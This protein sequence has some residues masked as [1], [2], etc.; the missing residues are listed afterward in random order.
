MVKVRISDLLAL[1]SNC[2][3]MA[4]AIDLLIGEEQKFLK[5]ESPEKTTAVYLEPTEWSPTDFR[6]P[7]AVQAILRYAVNQLGSQANLARRIIHL[8]IDPLGRSLS[9]LQV[10]ISAWLK[11]KTSPQQHNRQLLTELANK[12]NIPRTVTR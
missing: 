1:K 5:L 2:L 10:A 12:L 8:Q 11:N 4:G 6:K 3:A 7:V 9:T